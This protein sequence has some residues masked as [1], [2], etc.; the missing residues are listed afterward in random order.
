MAEVKR[1]DV[2]DWRSQIEII[3]DGRFVRFEDYSELE[4]KV[5]IKTHMLELIQA[6]HKFVGTLHDYE[7]VAEREIDSEKGSVGR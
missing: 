1:Y 2:S 3:N 4:R 5:K 6:E 7:T